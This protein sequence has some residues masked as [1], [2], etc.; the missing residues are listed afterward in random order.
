MAK[1]H[2]R[3]ITIVGNLAYITLTKG[4][5]AVV[6][7]EDA[8]LVACDNWQAKERGSR[9][10]A[11]RSQWCG[12]HYEERK[13]H[14][15]IIGASGDHSVDHIDGD[16]L[17]NRRSNLRLASNLQNSW[18]QSTAKNNASGYRGV[19]F[20]KATSRWRARIQCNGK[21][22]WLGFHSTA[23]DAKAAYDAAA[24][25]LYGEFAR[26]NDERRAWPK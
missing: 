11:C 10:Y 23:V 2:I 26:L 22:H 19:D 1:K 16:G 25:T 15:V 20:D 3:P 13:M 18:N 6:D 14:R 12:G 17:N 4:Y 9:T 21:S 5:V 8:H 24:M 7:A